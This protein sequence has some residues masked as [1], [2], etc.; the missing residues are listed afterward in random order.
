MDSETY[1]ERGRDIKRKRAVHVGERKKE[2]MTDRERRREKE[3]V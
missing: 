3:R 2:S 1:E